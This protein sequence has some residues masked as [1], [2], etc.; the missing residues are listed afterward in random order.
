MCHHTT[1][2]TMDI[3]LVSSADGLVWKRENNRKPLIPLGKR[4][5]FDCG[6]VFTTASP[7]LWNGKV[8]LFYEG[9]SSVHD[10][11][12]RYAGNSSIIRN[13]GLAE[14]KENVFSCFQK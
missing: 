10:G 14:F 2:Q 8:L 1:D 9:R 12:P 11:K 7:L 6:M 3:Q 5:Q 4:G 13:I